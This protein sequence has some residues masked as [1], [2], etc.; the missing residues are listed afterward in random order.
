MCLTNMA[1]WTTPKKE[2]LWAKPMKD[3]REEQ[4]KTIRLLDNQDYF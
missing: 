3:S 4:V 2:T 1:T